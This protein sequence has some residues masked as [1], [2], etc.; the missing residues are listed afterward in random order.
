MSIASEKILPHPLSTSLTF[1]NGMASSGVGFRHRASRTSQ[2]YLPESMSA[3][4][5]MLDYDG[6]GRLD[7]FFVNGAALKDPMTV[8]DRPD[9]T[10]PI[11]W[12]RLYH[13]N[14]DGTFTDVTIKA[15]LQG[16]SYGMGVAVADYDNDGLPDIYVTN[17]GENIL[18]HNNGDGT[19]TDVTRQAGVAAGGWST[20]ACF[21]DYNRDGL[22]DL[23]V[24]RYVEWNFSR[25]VICGGERPQYRS[26]CHPDLFPATTHLLYRNN[27]DGTFTDVTSES[28]IAKYPGKGL[29]VAINDFN[30]D[31]WPDIAVANDSHPQQLFRNN[32]DGTFTESALELGLAYD[33]G[34]NVFAGMGIDFADYNDDGWPDIFIN[35]LARQRYALFRND[36]G[37]S[38][39]Y[40]TNSSGLG[41]ISLLHSGWGA[42]FLD[43][44]NDG[45]K[46][47]FI[48]QGHVMDNI[49][50]LQPWI[51]HTEPPMLLH[52]DHG[53]FSDASAKSGR[54]FATALAARGAA[55]GDL[56]NDG[57]IDVVI[58]CND[59]P[60]V[61]LMNNG[62][63]NHWLIV[64]LI[65]HKSNR[66][67][68][69]SRVKLISRS[70]K[71][72]YGYVSTAGSYLSASDKRV[73][74]GLG[75]ETQ[76]RLIEITWPDGHIQILEA[77]NADQILTVH[78]AGKR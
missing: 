22:L 14:G 69:G 54:P 13:N 38:C 42:H 73:H 62:N 32:G 2:K 67:G 33:D 53:S 28:G 66:D 3:G 35:A 68:I 30:Q 71:A 43:Y 55:F 15:G 24:S 76:A 34:G 59:S 65:G 64:Q 46:D 49:A 20:G 1:R 27:G 29:G 6:D 47:L 19:F 48:A 52:Y 72:Q 12:N 5:A 25:N 21:V 36:H 70:G 37:T 18:Y 75:E 8:T 44:D 74:F 50:M 78:E 56:N 58:N 51:H 17:L 61:I 26:Y 41:R 31:G 9:K 7:L 4:V 77:I 10:N 63:A 11:Y 16:H 45:V 39:E 60:P 23:M 57:F 40:V